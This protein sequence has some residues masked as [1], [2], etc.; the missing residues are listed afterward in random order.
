M[1]LPWEP[2]SKE[3]IEVQGTGRAFGLREQAGATETWSVIG[4]SHKKD[5]RDNHMDQ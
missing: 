4:K 3:S 5:K 1:S 2:V